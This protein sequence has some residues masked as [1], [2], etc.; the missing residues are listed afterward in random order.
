MLI[1]FQLIIEFCVFLFSCPCHH[2][3]HNSS[4]RYFPAFIYLRPSNAAEH[5]NSL[6]SLAR[7]PTMECQLEMNSGA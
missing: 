4:L 6:Q 7:K 5:S 2:H 3:V 1:N